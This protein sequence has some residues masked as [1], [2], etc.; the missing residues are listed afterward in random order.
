MKNE[1]K[2]CF[3]CDDMPCENLDRID[4]RYRKRYDMSMVENLV[5]LKE[6]GMKK[7][8]DIQEDRYKCPKCGDVISVHDRKC[9]ACGHMET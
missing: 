9:Y 5:E 2:F 1:V 3:E 6:K 4:R 8:L 7:F